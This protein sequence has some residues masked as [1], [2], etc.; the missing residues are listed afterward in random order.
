[1]IR[2]ERILLATDFSECAAAAQE[3]AVDFTEK[4]GSRLHVLHVIAD[5]TSTWQIGMQIAL[6]NYAQD[7]PQ[8]MLEA[9][10]QYAAEELAKLFPKSGGPNDPLLL[11]RKGKPFVQITQ[12]ASEEQIDLIVMGTRG[13]GM[14]MHALMGSVAENV[15]RHAGCPVLTVHADGCPSTAD[16]G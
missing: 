12:Y 9:Q 3:Y 11:I 10:E 16:G 1:M 8:R 5:P 7:L 15:V 4:F 6:P 13:R 14:V 2:M